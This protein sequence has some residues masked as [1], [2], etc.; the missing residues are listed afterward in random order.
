MV[1]KKIRQK[2]VLIIDTEKREFVLDGR[3]ISDCVLEWSVIGSALNT[4]ATISIASD[5]V[6]KTEAEIT[7]RMI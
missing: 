3:D 7:E 6:I 4:T 5:V 1:N 2:H